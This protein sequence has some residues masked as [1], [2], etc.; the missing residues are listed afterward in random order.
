MPLLIYIELI[1]TEIEEGVTAIK[2][3]LI[4]R[5][6]AAETLAKNFTAILQ[7]QG[8]ELV[9]LDVFEAEPLYDQFSPPALN[10]I[11]LIISLGGPMSANDDYPAIS[12]EIDYLKRAIDGETPVIGICLGAQLLARALGGT[13]EPSGGHQF[14]L[15]KILVTGEG[16]TDPV[17]SKIKTPLVP[18][19]HGDCFSIPSGAIK[20]A[21]GQMLRRN[22]TYQRIN[23]A[24]RYGNSYGFQFEPQLTFEELKVWDTVFREEYKLMGQ[25]FD[26]A[27]ESARFL[28]EFAQF[29]QFHRNQ[30]RELLI[31]F[32]ANA[33]LVN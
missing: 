7:D 20:L 30:M 4:I 3:A 31:A 24:F 21:E 17:F 1:Y 16:L 11:D 10:E 6:H 29:E 27:E 32:L 2:H 26:P 33:G 19:L 13:V 5:H 14:G 18:T 28:G 22:S 9:P 23:M 25:W 15:T 12:S 8:F